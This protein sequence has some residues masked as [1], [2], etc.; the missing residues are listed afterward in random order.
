[1][2]IRRPPPPTS[3]AVQRVAKPGVFT[4]VPTESGPFT[5]FQIDIGTDSENIAAMIKNAP[6]A[7]TYFWLFQ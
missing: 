6:I 5:L 4:P 3:S 1:M 7:A 2:S